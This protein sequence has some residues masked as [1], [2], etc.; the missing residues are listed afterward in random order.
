MFKIF[1]I[2]IHQKLIQSPKKQ[3]LLEIFYPDYDLHDEKEKAIGG[4]K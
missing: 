3:N 1:K 2:P 4:L